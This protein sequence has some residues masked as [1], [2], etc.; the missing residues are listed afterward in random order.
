[1]CLLQTDDF[2]FQTTIAGGDCA[3]YENAPENDARRAHVRGSA[4]IVVVVVI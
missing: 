3:N 1:V 2:G 4:I